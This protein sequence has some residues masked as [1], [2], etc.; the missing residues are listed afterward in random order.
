VELRSVST[1]PPASCLS[2]AQLIAFPEELATASHLILRGLEESVRMGSPQEHATLL[3]LSQGY[4][5]LLKVALCLMRLS[6]DGCIPASLRSYGHKVGTLFSAVQPALARTDDPGV[7][8]DLVAI[9]DDPRYPH[10]FWM[11]EAWGQGG[12]Y[13]DLD[14]ILLDSVQSPADRFS[15]PRSRLRELGVVSIFA[16]DLPREW[17]N[18]DPPIPYREAVNRIHRAL[19]AF[20]QRPARLISRGFEAGAFGPLAAYF[21]PCLYPFLVDDD[22]LGTVGEI[23]VVEYSSLD[24][25][26]YGPM[27][28]DDAW[29]EESERLT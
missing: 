18:V 28:D 19:T 4:E 10:F 5:R 25:G 2:P 20:L 21:S 9:N 16:S 17:P 23:Q 3:L 13:F 11:L 14:A 7:R 29:L 8:E 26:F 27:E 1:D 12:R 24:D 15:D 6:S 22:S